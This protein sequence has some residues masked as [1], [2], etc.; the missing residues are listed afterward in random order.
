M[1]SIDYRALDECKSLRKLV[2]EAVKPPKM[3][4]VNKNWDFA[5]ENKKMLVYV[6]H[7]SLKAYKAAKGWKRLRIRELSL[8][9]KL[10]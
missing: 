10:M 8:N 6:P 9:T 7:G 4:G 5:E 2:V 3:V 1:K